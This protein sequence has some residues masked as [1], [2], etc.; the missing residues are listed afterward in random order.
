MRIALTPKNI[1]IAALS[2]AVAG[3]AAV[4]AVDHTAGAPPSTVA[5]TANSSVA[6]SGASGFT[7]GGMAQQLV[8]R[9]A[10]ELG[11]SAAQLKSDVES[12]QSID[13]IIAAGQAHGGKTA[14]QV[15]SDVLAYVSVALGDLVA[16]HVITAAQVAPLT[17]DATDFIDQL[18]AAHLGNAYT[19]Q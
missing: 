3:L 16:K 10:Q 9:F 15:R 5:L 8:D 7:R 13:D 1:A 2:V 17:Q 12:G 4:V 18:F 14:S 19:G 6:Q 11:I